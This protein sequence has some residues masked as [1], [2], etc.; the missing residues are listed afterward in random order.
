MI[1]NRGQSGA[2]IFFIQIRPSMS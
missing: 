2:S 1:L